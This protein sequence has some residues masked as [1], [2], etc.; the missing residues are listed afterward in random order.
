MKHVYLCLLLLV[1]TGFP[2]HPLFASFLPDSTDRS[3]TAWDWTSCCTGH[4]MYASAN[5]SKPVKLTVQLPFYSTGSW[6]ADALTHETKDMWPEDGWV[7]AYKDFGTSD[8][9]PAYPFFVLY[10]RYKGTFR[11]MVY[12][13]Q[14][15][16]F[17]YFKLT[18]SFTQSPAPLFTFTEK[19]GQY[20]T[21]ERFDPSVRQVVVTQ[22]TKAQ[23]WI[24]GDFLMTGYTPNLSP[25]ATIRLDV[26]GVRHWISG[27]N[28]DAWSRVLSGGGAGGSLIGDDYPAAVRNGY[29]TFAGSSSV[30]AF[31]GRTD[32]HNTLDYW[33]SAG[34]AA[35]IDY[36]ISG[37]DGFSGYEPISFKNQPALHV[38]K[39]DVYPLTSY[40]FGLGTTAT[41]GVYPALQPVSWGIFN[42]RNSLDWINSQQTRTQFCPGKDQHV[43]DHYATRRLPAIELA[44]NPD[45]PMHLV[46]SQATVV[47]PTGSPQFFD[48]AQL[49]E[50]DFAFRGF[51][52]CQG[53]EVDKKALGV[54]LR[55][56]FEIRPPL[57][58]YGKRMAFYKIYY[59]KSEDGLFEVV[60]SGFNAFPNPSSGRITF[61]F[62]KTE[63]GTICIYDIQGSLITAYSGTDLSLGKV[64]WPG[65]SPDGTRY[66]AG[67]YI[68]RFEDG[69]GKSTSRR[70]VKIP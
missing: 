38:L 16:A 4:T 26:E 70:L 60:S 29:K 8:K 49:P 21:L 10:N 5:G 34:D 66:P 25:D 7:L 17:T 31:L 65:A 30:G 55:L 12:N 50:T 3:E 36:L 67:T 58:A 61:T 47:Y 2:I 28:E 48:L 11:V 24:C 1:A 64:D 68:V 18:L 32:P 51:D 45:L 27:Q 35:A 53:K 59:S 41:P 43:T 23:G 39:D 63:T 69:Q 57:K 40:H 9:A 20:Q 15:V 54:G 46:S 22:A 37:Q 33:L 13:A 42:V 56:E 44:M 14:T 62:P 19:R 6:L 52:N